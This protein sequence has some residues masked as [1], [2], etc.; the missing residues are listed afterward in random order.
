MSN[1]SLNT[2]HFLYS[3]CVIIC[4]YLASAR[5]IR[6]QGNTCSDICRNKYFP[7][8]P[9]FWLIRALLRS[10]RLCCNRLTD[11]AIQFRHVNEIL[12]HQL[13]KREMVSFLFREV[14]LYGCYI[15]PF[16][17]F[18]RKIDPVHKFCAQKDL[19]YEILRAAL[20]QNGPFFWKIDLKQESL[21][22]ENISLRL[23][24]RF[25]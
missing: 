12:S 24:R 15:E 20:G 17:N 2:F 6:S 7:Y 21:P 22:G 16:R 11:N 19:R 8:G 25:P 13:E 9:S 18:E 4:S 23:R 3:P 10:I 5:S 14:Q 1:G